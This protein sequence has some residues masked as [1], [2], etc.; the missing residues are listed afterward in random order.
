MKFLEKNNFFILIIIGALLILPPTS[1]IRGS[2]SPLMS[3][4]FNFRNTVSKILTRSR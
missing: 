3:R 1:N 4:V 2:F